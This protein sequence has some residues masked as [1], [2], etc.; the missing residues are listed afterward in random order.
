[1]LRPERVN[2]RFLASC[3]S[4]QVSS[5]TTGGKGTPTHSSSGRSYTLI[6]SSVETWRT[7]PYHQVPL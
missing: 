6:P 2:R 4:S 1:M 7:L 5:S 3:A